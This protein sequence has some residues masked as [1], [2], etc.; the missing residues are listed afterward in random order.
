MSAEAT[1]HI[2]VPHWPCSRFIEKSCNL[3]HISLNTAD[4]SQQVW[5]TLQSLQ[6][7]SRSLLASPGDMAS[8]GLRVG[9]G[10][11]RL[12]NGAL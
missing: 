2:L 9:G 7:Q 12:K 1:D 3:R 6:Y 11:A 5:L 10:E 4:F 8:G